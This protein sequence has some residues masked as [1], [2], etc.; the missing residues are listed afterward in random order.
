MDH[1]NLIKREVLGAFADMRVPSVDSDSFLTEEN[2]R[3]NIYEQKKL[4]F[5]LKVHFLTGIKKSLQLATLS[6]ICGFFLRTIIFRSSEFVV[7][8]IRTC[9]LCFSGLESPTRPVKQKRL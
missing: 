9:S 7:D 3:K 2:L 6:F 1:E 5:F 4:F 8:L